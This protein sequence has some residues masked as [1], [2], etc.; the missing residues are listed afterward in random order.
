MASFVLLP[1]RLAW[2]EMSGRVILATNS[3]PPTIDG[4]VVCLT[5]FLEIFC[6]LRGLR[7]VSA[8]LHPRHPGIASSL[9]L[10]IGFVLVLLSHQTNAAPSQAC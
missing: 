7:D 9:S 8:F 3:S 2:I 1:R 5:D 6:S 4:G 10:L